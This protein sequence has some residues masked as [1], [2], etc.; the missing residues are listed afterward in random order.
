MMEADLYEKEHVIEGV[1]EV[2]GVVNE[3]LR[4]LLDNEELLEKA[5]SL[6]FTETK[7]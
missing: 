2:E 6:Y 5:V 7:A 3:A 4:T 1:C